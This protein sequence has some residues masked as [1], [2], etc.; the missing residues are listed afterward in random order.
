MAVMAEPL[1]KRITQPFF[2]FLVIM[3]NHRFTLERYR[4]GGSNRYT[5]P[6]CGRKKCFTRYVDTTTGT[7]VDDTC[8]KCDHEQRCG[9]HYRPREFFHDNAWRS[10][11]APP[12]DPQDSLAPG[13]DE[14]TLV[15]T[16][17]SPNSQFVQWL[18]TRIGDERPVRRVYDDYRLGATRDGG[19]IFWQIG[20]D[21]RARAGKIM[22]YNADG[23]RTGHPDWVHAVLKRRGRYPPDYQPPKCLFGEHLLPQRPDDVVCLVEGEKTA[24]ACAARYPDC[25]WLATG[26]CSMLTAERLACLEGRRVFVWPDS[27]MLAKWRECLAHADTLHYTLVDS[28]ERYPPN[29]DLADLL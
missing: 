6:H 12:A 3:D 2:K 1:Q 10:P 23:H 21:G 5:C 9:Y 18:L 29:T 28:L 25:L 27:G 14:D 17:H 20:A 11:S 8:G 22:H 26:G 4:S 7:Y 15:V 19:V 24:V 13:G 16:C